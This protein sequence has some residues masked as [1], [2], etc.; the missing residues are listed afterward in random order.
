MDALASNPFAAHKSELVIANKLFS[1]GLTDKYEYE[2]P[3]D[4]TVTPGRMRP[5][6]SFVDAAGDLIIWEHLGMLAR[7]D[8]RRGWEWKKEWYS[9]NG[10]VIEQNLFTTEDDERGGLDSAAITATAEKIGQL[11]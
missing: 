2:R 11:L 7:E 6:F 9:K 5:D 4:G 10:F 1:L 8:Y 3:F